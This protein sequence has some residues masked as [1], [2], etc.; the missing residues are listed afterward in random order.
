MWVAQ[1][2]EPRPEFATSDDLDSEELM[3]LFPQY[4]FSVLVAD[5]PV[6]ICRPIDETVLKDGD[7][8]NEREIL[9]FMVTHMLN[10]IM[11]ERYERVRY[12]VE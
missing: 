9:L 12:H 2:T 11:E 4:R 6:I 3:D 8:G 10:V 1:V 7:A 5:K